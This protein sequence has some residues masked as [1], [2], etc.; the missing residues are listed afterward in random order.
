MTR[1]A[2][3]YRVTLL[4][5][6]VNVVLVALKFVC[7]I[8]G[9]SAAMIADAVHSLSDL[10]TD[11]VVL[12]FV[13]LGSRPADADHHYGHG[14]YET[15]ATLIVGAALLAVAL[16][17]LY[18]A[19]QK[20]GSA[21]AG[22]SLSVPGWPALVAALVSI[23]L[24]EAVYHLTARV[25]RRHRSEAVIANAWHHRSDALSSIGTGLGIGGAILLGPEWAVLD[26]LA[27]AVVAVFI[28]IAAVRLLLRAINELLE[29]S[30]PPEVEDEIRR[31]VAL[32]PALT[33]L[34]HLRTRAVGSVYSI[35]MHLRMPGYTTLRDAHIHTI[36]LEERLR[37]RFGEE[38]MVSLH[39]EPLKVNGKYL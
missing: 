16:V 25:G 23:A 15:L 29:K 35:D 17:L 6:L 1:N 22:Q 20:I 8:V 7:G 21:M 18:E 30:L 38:T 34:H 37:N 36:Q 27:A 4:G 31:I 26:P 12:V 5:G 33:E 11:A 9:A 3:I 39:M 2:E 13:R 10:A 14:K 24:K 28:A 19:G 32:D